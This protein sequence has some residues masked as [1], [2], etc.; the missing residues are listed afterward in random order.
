[1]AL[2]VA[3][4]QRIHH[5]ADVGRVLAGLADVRDLDQF[6]GGLVQVALELLV[7]VEV[8]VG[9]LDDDVPFEQE[10][11]EHFLD[12][13]RRVMG[14]VGAEGDVLQVEEHRH[15][16]VGVLR[17]HDLFSPGRA[18]VHLPRPSKREKIRRCSSKL[19]WNALLR[20]LGF[21]V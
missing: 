14:I 2:G 16:R 7:A 11:F 3:E 6:E 20:S 17:V 9:L 21:G 1:M 5:H 10:A 8:A 15:G 19:E 12:V 4:V 13:E 18:Q